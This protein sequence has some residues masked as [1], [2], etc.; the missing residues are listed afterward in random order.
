M[1]YMTISSQENH[2]FSL[3]SYFHAHPTTLLLKILG[4]PMHGPS[5]LKFWA[6]VPP[7]SP[8]LPPGHGDHTIP[9]PKSTPSHPRLTPIA[10][11]RRKTV[12]CYRNLIL[13][14]CLHEKSGCRVQTRVQAFL[15]PLLSRSVSLAGKST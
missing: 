2:H 14:R 7:R 1:S 13:I 8:R 12:F 4:E 9:I 6:T 15:S 11:H 5:P 10:V 3:C